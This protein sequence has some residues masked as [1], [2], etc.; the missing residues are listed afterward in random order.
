MRFD[1]I[2][3]QY[4]HELLPLTSQREKLLREI[5]ELRA[6][7]DSFLE[8]ATIL[9]ARNEELA[10]LGAQYVRRVDSG[11]ELDRRGDSLDKARAAILNAS[12]TSS[13]VALSDESGEK[14]IKISKPELVDAP[15]PQANTR[16]FIKWP[17]S[18]PQPPKDVPVT[19]DANKAKTRV[20]HTFQ[21]IS[22][23]RVSRCDHCGDK[24]WGSQLRC[25][26]KWRDYSGNTWF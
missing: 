26:G 6:A 18:R 20:E 19:N 12:V 21:Q 22:M 24:M 10:Q 15:A 9:N 13:T 11:V 7:R 2:K 4:Q 1:N 3:V 5:T 25:S 16:K 17:G 8:E 23:L 14:F